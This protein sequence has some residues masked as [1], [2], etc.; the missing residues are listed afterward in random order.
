MAL[1][2]GLVTITGNLG[3]EPML[4]GKDPGR[5]ACVFRLGCTRRYMDKTGVWQQ[6]PTTWIAV[7]AFRALALNVM[8]SLRK[9]DA[10]IVCGVLGTEQWTSEDGVVHSRIVIEASNVGHD[11]NYGITAVRKIQKE[12]NADAKESRTTR[13]PGG[14]AP[15]ELGAPNPDPAPPAPDD[16]PQGGDEER[17]GPGDFADGQR[18]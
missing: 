8:G 15:V 18:F 2:Q 13:N 16:E 1:Q 12:Q 5:P 7:K 3:N 14:D 11:L 10:V 6:L 4:Y 9:G 17:E